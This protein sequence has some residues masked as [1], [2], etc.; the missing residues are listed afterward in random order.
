MILLCIGLTRLYVTNDSTTGGV[1]N[2][3][4]NTGWNETITW[5]TKPS[6]DG[7]LVSTLGSVALNSAV[8]VYLTNVI[9]GNG[10]YSFAIS[11]P[12][13]S[14]NTVGYASREASTAGTRLQ[15]IILLQ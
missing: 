8:D 5:R 3:I 6:I 1:F 11:L 14:T 10:I 4:S 9:T 13:G 12:S 2:R 15:L 7:A